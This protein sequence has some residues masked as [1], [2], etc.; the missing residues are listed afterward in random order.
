MTTS[1]VDV[2]GLAGGHV[3][4]TSAHLAELAARIEGPML[5]PGD[6]GWGDAGAVWNGMVA[7]RPALVI[8]PSSA[9][10]VAAA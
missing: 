6:A 1:T 5:Y 9:D 8:Q 4:L 3:S 2:A 7:K 10:D